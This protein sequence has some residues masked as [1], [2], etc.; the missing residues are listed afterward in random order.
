MTGPEET[1][2]AR[3][4]LVLAT[5]NQHKLR[6]LTRILATGHV[7]VDLAGLA[8]FPGAPEVPETGATFSETR[9]DS[10]PIENPSS[11]A[12]TS[13]RTGLGSEASMKGSRR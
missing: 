10:C 7:D 9:I 6:E 13:R 4:R 12:V 3:A 2:P 5:A 11:R 8:E 1:G